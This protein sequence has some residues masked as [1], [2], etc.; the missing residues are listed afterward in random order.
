MV[1]RQHFDTG[2]KPVSW[3]KEV[4][5]EM[6]LMR[7]NKGLHENGQHIEL[8][9]SSAVFQVVMITQVALARDTF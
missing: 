7:N 6:K 8:E 2:K 3:H 4:F 9:N 1:S 5:L